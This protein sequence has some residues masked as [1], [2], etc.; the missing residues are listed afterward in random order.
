MADCSRSDGPQAAQRIAKLPFRD[1]DPTPTPMAPIC[2][3]QPQR[4]LR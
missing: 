3:N 4:A 1:L 2:A